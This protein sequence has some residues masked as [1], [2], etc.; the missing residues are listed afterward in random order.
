[1]SEKDFLNLLTESKARLTR[2]CR[3]YC[4]RKEDQQD[5]MQ[6]IVFQIWRSRDRFRRESQ[7]YTWI[8]RIG[9]NT[10][11]TFVRKARRHPY[12]DLSHAPPVADAQLSP[13]ERMDQ[14][15][16]QSQLMDA[17]RQLR[18]LDQ[19]LILLYLEE[20]SYREMAEITGLSE[21]NVGVKINRIKK[22]LAQRLTEKIS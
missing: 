6:E 5:L 19:T 4:T 8:Y 22:V 17:I 1:M 21:S 14:A 2:I 13:E 9:I 10:A 11:L 3:F 20:M 18:K 12:V 16:Q 15:E 7:V